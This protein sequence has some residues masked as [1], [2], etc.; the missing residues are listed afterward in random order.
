MDGTSFS[1]M[2]GLFL[3][4][5]NLREVTFHYLIRVEALVRTACAYCFSELHRNADDY[6]RAS[7]YATEEEYK[8]YGLKGRASNVVRLT[9]CL[10][11]RAQTSKTEFVQHYREIYGEVPL[12]VLA[13]DLTFGNV[14][15]FFNLMKP[16]EQAAVCKHIVKATDRYGRKDKSLGFFH[17]RE[18]RRSIDY[19]VKY[20]N[21]CAHDDRLY[22]ARVGPHRECGFANMLRRV[23]RFLTEEEYRDLVGGVI[24]LL[25]RSAAHNPLMGHLIEN[26]GFM[27][28]KRGGK[29]YVEF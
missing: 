19:L 17:P 5:R 27:T 18:A 29:T 21:I 7:S 3:F 10:Q 25:N 15:H 28:S 12:W 24:D 16:N 13:N 23:E 22:C 20:R 14:Q 26:M 4:D 6:L 1:D 2:Y 11:E 8:S 9:S